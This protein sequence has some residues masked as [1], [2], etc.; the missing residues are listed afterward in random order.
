[1]TE[2]FEKYAQAYD[3]WFIRHESIRRLAYC[4]EAQTSFDLMTSSWKNL[5]DTVSSFSAVSYC[6]SFAKEARP[7]PFLGR[8]RLRQT[9]LSAN[10]GLE[11]IFGDI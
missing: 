10:G 1:M 5:G 8:F 4:P 11:F 6:G 9:Q 3:D 7:K 2:V